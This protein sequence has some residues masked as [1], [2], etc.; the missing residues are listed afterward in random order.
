MAPP[1]QKAGYAKAPFVPSDEKARAARCEEIIRIQAMGL[2]KRLIHT[3]MSRA[4]LGISGGLDVPFSAIRLWAAKTR[5]V[6]DSP[7]PA[8]AYT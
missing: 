7:S 6:V 3:G 5:S 1:R 4:V 8:S 2:K